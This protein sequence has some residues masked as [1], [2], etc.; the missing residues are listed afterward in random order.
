MLARPGSNT[1]WR[2]ATG[3]L[4]NGLRNLGLNGYEARE[5]MA[6]E[7]ELEVGGGGSHS[8]ECWLS[9]NIRQALRCV[10]CTVACSLCPLHACS[11][12]THL[13]FLHHT[14]PA[15]LAVRQPQHTRSKGGS[16]ARQG[17]G[18][19]GAATGF[20][21]VWQC[22]DDVAGA[23]RCLLAVDSN[24]VHVSLCSLLGVLMN[25][26]CL[27]LFAVLKTYGCVLCD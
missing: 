26:Y 22:G 19:A 6:L 1:A 10:L 12:A 9:A 21:G 15:V 16:T 11:P 4:V 27:E 3:A 25:M 24:G 20:P 14:Q 23:V 5:M 8:I 13:P 17:M 2:V 18:G 7:N